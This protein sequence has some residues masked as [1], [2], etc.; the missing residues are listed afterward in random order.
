[1]WQ[2]GRAAIEWSI[3]CCA[4]GLLFP[5]LAVAGAGFALRA[6]HLGS[7]RWLAALLCAVWCAV[8]GGTLRVGLN[9]SLV[10]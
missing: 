8:L 10:P 3:L 2:P 9:F 4:A 5:V 6:R 7:P 1:V